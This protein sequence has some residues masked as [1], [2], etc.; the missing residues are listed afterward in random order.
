MSSI[1]NLVGAV[2]VEPTQTYLYA[3]G[4]QPLELTN[5]QHTH[6]WYPHSESNRDTLTFEESRFTKLRMRAMK[7]LSCK[8]AVFPVARKH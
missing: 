2:G 1:Y 5:A 4:L 6:G 3:G 8:R 7:L